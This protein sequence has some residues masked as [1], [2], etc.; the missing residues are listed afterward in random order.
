MLFWRW[1]GAAR[2]QLKIALE[3]AADSKEPAH[4]SD[5]PEDR[6]SEYEALVAGKS[7]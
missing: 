3:K 2:E 5:L 1:C 4:F 6:Q 7:L